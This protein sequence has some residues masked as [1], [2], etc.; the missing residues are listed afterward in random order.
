MYILN[1]GLDHYGPPPFIYYSFVGLERL[2]YIPYMYSFGGGEIL[3]MRSCML[4]S[5]SFTYP[6]N[7][8]MLVEG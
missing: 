3:A 1:F 2:S 6:A 8:V 5:Y 4:D 7:R